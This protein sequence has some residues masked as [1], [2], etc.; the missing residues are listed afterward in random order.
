MSQDRPLARLA[1]LQSRA[2]CLSV[3]RRRFEA[4]DAE[5]RENH[6]WDRERSPAAPPLPPEK[7]ASDGA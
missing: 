6:F 3:R 1:Q 7:P 2:A 4:R 5:Y